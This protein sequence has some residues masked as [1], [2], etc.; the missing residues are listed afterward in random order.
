M[1]NLAWHVPSF[2]VAYSVHP[3]IHANL[4]H[5]KQPHV[6]SSLKLEAG[7]IQQATHQQFVSV[8]NQRFFS[9]V[10]NQLLK[11][12]AEDHFSH[13]A[14]TA[15]REWFPSSSVQ[16][17]VRTGV[18]SPHSK[19]SEIMQGNAHHSANAA[20]FTNLVIS[21]EEQKFASLRGREGQ[22][23]ILASPTNKS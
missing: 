7:G 20:A 6:T 5:G 13:A 15:G 11:R 17:R 3:C 19:S 2:G 21:I 14:I 12:D 9:S 18:L 23:F 4:F 22:G 8:A 10:Q 1:K 16:A